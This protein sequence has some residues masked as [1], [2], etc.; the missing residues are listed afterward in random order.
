MIVNA[1]EIKKILEDY[2]F[3]FSG[4]MVMPVTI[5]LE[6]GDTI[7]FGRADGTITI[8]LSQKPSIADVDKL[9]P[10]EDISIYKSHLVAC[11]HRTRIVTN[12]SPEQQHEWQKT[13]K[14]ISSTVQ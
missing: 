2:D 14:E 12:L 13:I 8:R 11:Q 6:A 5:D 1:P 4:G 3:T 10:A 7:N 9:L